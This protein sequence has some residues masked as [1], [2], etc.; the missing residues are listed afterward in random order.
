METTRFSLNACRNNNV[1]E[2]MLTIWTNDNAECDLFA[3]LFDLS[4]FAELC[5]DKDAS[6]EKL[7]A[8]FEA[9]TGGD[10]D[11]FYAMSFYHN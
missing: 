9:C 5:Y 6:P 10:Y 11:A 3:N 4:Y 2:A 1:R 7:R 8:R